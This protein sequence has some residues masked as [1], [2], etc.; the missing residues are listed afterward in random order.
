MVSPAVAKR[1]KQDLRRTQKGIGETMGETNKKFLLQALP[2]TEEP[3]LLGGRWWGLREGRGRIRKGRPRGVPCRWLGG[4]DVRGRKD[5]D[6]GEIRDQR[7][8]AQWLHA[9]RG[10]QRTR[11]RSGT[12][13]RGR[14][15]GT[16]RGRRWDALTE[17]L[18]GCKSIGNLTWKD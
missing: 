4:C 14:R 13:G 12:G 10:E 3:I 6:E 15:D 2:A 11:P 7:T 5:G 18:T 17:A 1:E 8:S 9:A 16:G